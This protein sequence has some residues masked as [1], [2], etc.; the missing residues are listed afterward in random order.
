MRQLL[1]ILLIAQLVSAVSTNPTLTAYDIVKLKT[2]TPFSLEEKSNITPELNRH[3]KTYGT[4]SRHFYSYGHI[5]EKCDTIALFHFSPPK[6]KAVLVIVHGY[7][8]NSGTLSK[9]T[10]W[11][12]NRGYAVITMDLPGHGL[13]SGKR[14]S[15]QNFRQY[16]DAVSAVVEIAKKR[17]LPVH[18]L[19]HSTGC[20]PL[21]DLH[22]KKQKNW[23]GE[24][25]VVAPL[26]RSAMWGL[27]KAGA[28]IL[29]PFTKETTRLF[30]NSSHDENFKKHLKVD[31]LGVK[32]FP[33]EWSK[34]LYAWN[35]VIEKRK[36]VSS[37]LLVIQGTTDGTVDWRY[38]LKFLKK[39]FPNSQIVKV[40]KGRHHLLNE[41]PF[42][43]KKAFSLIEK[44]LLKNEKLT[45]L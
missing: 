18:T 12:L 11:A 42:Y 10:N 35:K 33:V 23:D 15:I 31:P 38:N 19:G 3:F 22:L 14:A 6:A 44:H 25:I 32:R 24:T 41:T 28:G 20:S 36:P 13:S 5:V 39:K 8:D 40:E 26:V 4:Q 21:I 37:E 45:K 34:A 27:S 29:K 43:A 9:V 30:R 7:F 2:F 1:F 16:T 17:K